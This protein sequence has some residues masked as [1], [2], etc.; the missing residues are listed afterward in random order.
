MLE[1]ILG[2]TFRGIITC[3]FYGAYRK[4]Q[5][6]TEALLQFCWAHFIR[7]VLFLLGLKEAA[8]RRY[9]RRIIK[10]IVEMFETIHRKG[11]MEEGEWKRLMHGHQELIVKRATATVP[12][13]NDAQ[14]IAKRMREWEAEY[15]RFI[16]EGIE[17]TN[18]PAELTIRQ[19]VLDR[20]VTQGSRGKR[21]NEWHE[22]FWSVFTTCSLQNSSVM[23]YLKNCLSA[24]FGMN[25]SPNLIVP[26][27]C[28]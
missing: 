27:E 22:R 2:T 3:D 21:G 25:H 24:Y 16:E 28:P 6:L 9:G 5:R 1:E 10:Q 8:V 23:H 4:F 11:D 7:E 26:A 13:Q 15:F 14:L 19:S 18:N 20:L 17:A 12:E